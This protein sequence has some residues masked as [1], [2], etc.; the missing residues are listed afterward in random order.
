MNTAVT[1]GPLHPASWAPRLGFA[2]LRL[3][4]LLPYRPLM[5]V[6]RLLG[7][8]IRMFASRRENIARINLALC[9]PDL[10]DAQRHALLKAHFESVGMGLMDF[11]IAWWW[12]D[13]RL[14]PLLTM[15]GTEHLA[16]A[17]ANGKGVIFFTGHFTSL[18]LS[19]RLLSRLAPALPMYRPNENPVI[20]RASCTSN[21]P[22]HV[23]MCA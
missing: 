11:A 20:E 9:F 7:R 15:T 8:V 10:T 22:F 5:A 13:A 6:G 18:E 3:V 1:N 17:F 16:P 21:A 19:G 2:A 4:S 12:S 23:T 14:D